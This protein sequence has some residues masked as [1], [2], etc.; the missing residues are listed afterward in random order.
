MVT[1][2]TILILL[3]LTIAITNW[4][5]QVAKAKVKGYVEPKRKVSR[6]DEVDKVSPLLGL[7]AIVIG[8]TIMVGYI[9]TNYLGK[10]GWWISESL[11]GLM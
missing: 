10:L 2:A 11:K 7:S 3:S 1:L 4:R 5:K 9:M 8:I 6:K